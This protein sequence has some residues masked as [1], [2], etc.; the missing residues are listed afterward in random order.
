MSP[1]KH[2][3]VWSCGIYCPLKLKS[4]ALF[5]K[6]QEVK[7]LPTKPELVVVNHICVALGYCPLSEPIPQ[8]HRLYSQYWECFVTTVSQTCGLAT[9]NGCKNNNKTCNVESL[10]RKSPANPAGLSRIIEEF[11][12]TN[13]NE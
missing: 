7:H 10:K 5:T 6:K 13:L 3:P 12:K 9:H 8:E 11:K 1:F 4:T 2:P